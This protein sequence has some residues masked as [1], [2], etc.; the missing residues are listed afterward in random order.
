MNQPMIHAKLHPCCIDT[1]DPYKAR[2]SFTPI[3][4]DGV[5][6]TLNHAGISPSLYVEGCLD[7]PNEI[8]CGSTK[9][10]MCLGGFV[11]EQYNTQRRGCTDWKAA[12]RAHLE[13]S[14]ML[15]EILEGVEE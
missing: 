9:N 1:W 11:R 2:A 15:K 12:E 3:L 8:P 7:A 14:K 10:F 6:D 5:F 4:D 13:V